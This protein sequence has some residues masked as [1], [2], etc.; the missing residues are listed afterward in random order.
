[1]L[2]DL[3]RR[4][5]GR[6]PEFV[7][8]SMFGPT[9]LSPDVGTPLTILIPAGAVAGQLAVGI[10]EYGRPYASFVWNSLD[11]AIIE[12]SDVLT[13][14][15]VCVWSKILT[16]A[17]IARGTMRFYVTG[18]STGSSP[19]IGAMDV[20]KSKGVYPGS[21]SLVASPT[22]GTTFNFTVPNA[23][24]TGMQVVLAIGY[25][26]LSGGATN[27]YGMIEP[28]GWTR[29]HKYGMTTGNYA[30]LGIDKVAV[31]GAGGGTFTMGA[32]AGSWNWAQVT[33]YYVLLKQW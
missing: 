18:T 27:R 23:A 2:S 5:S 25:G 33:T 28:A 4:V 30:Q 24:R 31:T 7:A 19:C 32:D 1:M 21:A 20:Y 6:R 9:S 16:S 17:D 14:H 10:L 29:R 22:S 26:T 13:N 12:R 11:G 8:A 3:L 15:F